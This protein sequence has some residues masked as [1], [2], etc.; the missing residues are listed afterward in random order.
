MILET[1]FAIFNLS[2]SIK[3]FYLFILGLMLR[4]A[5]RSF[6]L[7]QRGIITSKIKID[8][9][10]LTDIDKEFKDIPKENKTK[11]NFM[12]AIGMCVLGSLKWFELQMFMTLKAH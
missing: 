9:R 3:F 2:F 10:S 4:K 11:Q 7:S 5:F 8:E 6:L 1:K 12:A